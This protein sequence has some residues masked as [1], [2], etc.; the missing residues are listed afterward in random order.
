MHIIDLELNLMTMRLYVW[1]LPRFT[2][3]HSER[4]LEGERHYETIG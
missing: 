2:L 4:E 3:C 1:T